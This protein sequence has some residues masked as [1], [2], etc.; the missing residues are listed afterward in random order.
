MIAN[1]ERVTTRIN[2][3]VKDT[4]LTVAELSGV[5]LNQFLVHAA[6]EKA[7]EIIEKNK[8]IAL[9]KHDADVFFAALDNPPHANTKLKQA[10]ENYKKSL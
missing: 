2:S 6:L 5:T 3:Q 7:E 4:L 9:S 1:T 10:L 8:V